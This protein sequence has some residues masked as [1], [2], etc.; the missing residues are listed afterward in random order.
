MKQLSI[1]AIVDHVS[2]HLGY[3]VSAIIVDENLHYTRPTFVLMSHDK[4][5][6]T[7]LELQAN[8]PGAQLRTLL[9]RMQNCG[10]TIEMQDYIY[11]LIVYFE[12]HKAKLTRIRLGSDPRVQHLPIP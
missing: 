11:R 2:A 12:V 1:K 7:V 9:G 4:C 10:L 3:E 5:D 6:K 8:R